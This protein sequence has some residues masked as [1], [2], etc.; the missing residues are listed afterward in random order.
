MKKPIK[1]KK[2]YFTQYERLYW[3]DAFQALNRSAENLMMCLYS[4]LRFT[5]HKKRKTYTNNG[6]ISF[7]EIE[8]KKNK[9]GASQTYLNARNKLIKVGFIKQIY[10]GGMG[11]GDCC[12]YKLLWIEGVR[13]DEMRWKLYPKKDWEHEIP[14]AK[15]SLVGKETRFKK[16]KNTLGTKVLN[17]SNSPNSLDSFSFNRPKDLGW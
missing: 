13:H 16:K 17:N 4:E 7:T 6:E 12:K 11:P 14:K 9:L 2:F 8:F 10:R 15:G 1:E 3:S 5:L